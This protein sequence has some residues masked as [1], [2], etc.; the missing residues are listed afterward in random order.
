MSGLEQVLIILLSM[1]G[2]V[3][4][5]HISVN[6]KKGNVLASAI[7][8]FIA[9]VLHYIFP[10]TF[11][12]N[13]AAA[14]AAASYAGMV[15]GENVPDIRNCAIIGLMCGTI[16]TFST[17][18][19]VGVGGRLGTIAAISCGAYFGFKMLIESFDTSKIGVQETAKSNK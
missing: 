5:Y 15:S 16:F 19:Y 14:L 12:A 9:G 6:L 1:L 3:T 18:A 7:V 2:A 17:S 4:T 11:G 8:V 13:H 10:G